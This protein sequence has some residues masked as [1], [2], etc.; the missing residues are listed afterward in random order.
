VTVVVDPSLVVSALIDTGETGRWAESQLVTGPLSAPRLMPV[1]AANILR[2]SAAKGEITSDVASQAQ[3][4]LLDL[5]VELFPYASFG[6]HAYGSPGV[7]SRPI[8]DRPYA[9][10]ALR[11]IRR[12]RR[13]DKNI[14]AS[15]R[16][17]PRSSR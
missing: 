15:A 14:P 8:E 1:E 9:S 13:R 17:I 7:T 3:T 4:D 10:R 6:R 2:R 12:L 5:R 16:I 11:R